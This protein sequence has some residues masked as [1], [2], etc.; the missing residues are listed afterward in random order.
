M[1]RGVTVECWRAWALGA[2]L[3]PGGWGALAL[4]VPPEAPAAAPVKPAR[5]EDFEPPAEFVAVGSVKTH[6]VHKGESGPAV[7]LVHGFGASTYTWRA[8]LDALAPGC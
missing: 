3:G 5:V 8:T 2:V 4:A 1:R 7:V 6:Y